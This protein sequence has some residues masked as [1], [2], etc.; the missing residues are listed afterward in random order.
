MRPSSG[1]TITNIYTN[2]KPL[3]GYKMNLK[4]DNKMNANHILPRPGSDKLNLFFS[5]NG[6]EVGYLFTSKV[7]NLLFIFSILLSGSVG[8]S[9]VSTWT[10]GTSG[11]WLTSGNWSPSGAPSGTGAE[12]YININTQPTMGVNMNGITVANSSIGAVHFDASATS[13]RTIQNSSGTVGGTF[14]LNGLTINS[15]NNVILRNNSSANL[16]IQNGSN[17]FNL[18]LGNSTENV[19][20]IDGTGN[21]VINSVITGTGRNLVKGG[22]GS[23]VLELSNANTYSGL[24]TVTG[25]T[26]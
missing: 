6:K 26:L 7:T 9:Q 22:S 23:G 13:N 24:T 10:G 1:N 8:F 12:A 15:V 19:I 25:G 3:K 14:T 5:S 20:N 16:T 18:G 2:Q 21:I 4:T 17:T 11:A